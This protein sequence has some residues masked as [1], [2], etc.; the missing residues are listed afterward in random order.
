M[1]HNTF[2]PQAVDAVAQWNVSRLLHGRSL[3][4]N[5]VRVDECKFVLFSFGKI[6]Y[7]NGK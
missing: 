1:F 5:Q 4:R 6:G 3:V 7:V 2:F